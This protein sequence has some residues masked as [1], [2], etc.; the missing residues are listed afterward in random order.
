MADRGD[1]ARTIIDSGS[2]MTLAT[3]DAEGVPWAS[4]VWYAKAAYDELLWVSEPEA[5]HSR[6]IAARPQSAVVIFDSRAPLGGGQG[7]Y[8]TATAEQLTGAEREDGIAAF[9]AW[10]ESQGGSPWSVDDVCPPARHRLYRARV[11]QHW[12]LGEKDRRVP[13]RP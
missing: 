9:A 7:V 1:L 13:V 5:Q 6:N 11:S 2:Y 4:P 8:M 10:S 12:V 3:A